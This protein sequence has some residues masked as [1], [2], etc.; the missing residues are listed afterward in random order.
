VNGAGIGP[1]RLVEWSAGMDGWHYLMVRSGA[2]T[3][4]V[5][6]VASGLPASLLVDVVSM[7]RAGSGVVMMFR[8]F[9]AGVVIDSAPGRRRV[10][11]AWLVRGLRWMR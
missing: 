10:L 4:E 2:T 3:P 9:P 1:W 11:W 5:V 6:A 7:D 8:E